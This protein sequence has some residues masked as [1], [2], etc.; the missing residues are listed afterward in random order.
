MYREVQVFDGEEYGGWSQRCSHRMYTC[1]SI[2]RVRGSEFAEVKGR[3]LRIELL[4]FR[5]EC[6]GSSSGF[7]TSLG[8][9]I[10]KC[11]CHS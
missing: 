7:G 3:L 8:T 9:Y 10:A 1:C 6:S 2:S 5:Q 11:R 4:L